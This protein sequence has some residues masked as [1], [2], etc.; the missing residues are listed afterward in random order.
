MIG[1]HF[2]VNGVIAIAAL[3]TIGL[4]IFF[5][6]PLPPGPDRAMIG[7]VCV[8]AKTPRWICMAI[9]LGLCVANGAFAWP[10]NRAAQ[11]VIIFI[12][13]LV[14]GFGAICAGLAGLGVTSGVPDW[15]SR[16][17]ALST[18]MVPSVQIV[19]AAWF[20]N[21]G[22][23]EGL[24]AEAMRHTT[25]TFLAVFASL[26]CLFSL[27]GVFASVLTTKDT[28]ARRLEL[29]EGNQTVKL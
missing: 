15:L 22:L 9:L 3:L 11:Y 12:V 27:A 13:H 17:L 10:E 19:F 7:L 8:F 5:C 16:I 24:D 18:I 26:V 20:L 1:I 4:G 28:K 2:H 21:P 29:L 25:N 14:I 23:H 6:M